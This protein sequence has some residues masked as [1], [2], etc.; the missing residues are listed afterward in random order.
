[1]NYCDPD[2]ELYR[3]SDDVVAGQAV[4]GLAAVYPRFSRRDVE[5]VYVFRAPYVEPAW[6]VGYL[7]RRP[8]P[9]VGRSRLYVCSTAQAYPRV[10]AWNTSVSLAAETVTTLLD[11]LA[12]SAAATG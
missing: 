11:D 10:T 3:R 9:R 12:R 8:A 4:E 6:T 7:K 1:M 2:S 5:A